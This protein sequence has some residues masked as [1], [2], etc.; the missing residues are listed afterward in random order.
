MTVH[1]VLLLVR[2]KTPP[3]NENIIKRWWWWWSLPRNNPFN[4][5][6]YS[7]HLAEETTWQVMHVFNKNKY[8][9]KNMTLLAVINCSSVS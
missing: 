6:T 1:F 9:S 5:A 2:S 8:T 7:V 3:D 4:W